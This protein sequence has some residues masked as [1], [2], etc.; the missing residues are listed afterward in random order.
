MIESRSERVDGKSL[1]G[2]RRRARR[3][4]FRGRDLKRWDELR[5]RRN[6][7]RIRSGDR[8]DGQLRRLAAA[9]RDQQKEKRNQR[10]HTPI[11]VHDP[12]PH[13]VTMRESQKPEEDV[14]AKGN[15]A[16]KKETKKPKK[17]KK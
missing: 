13:C 11:G 5:L 12:F 17:D 3:P 7:G 10:A 14:M 16:R 9:I 2:D 8:R 4:S 1:R 15:N 6:Q